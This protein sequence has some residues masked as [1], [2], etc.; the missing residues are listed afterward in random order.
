MLQRRPSAFITH[1]AFVRPGFGAHHP[2]STGRQTAVV[3]LVRA[4]GWLAKGEEKI[5]PLPPRETLLRF[6]SPEYLSALERAGT[7]AMATA[8]DRARYNLGT[9]EC[10]VFDGLWERARASVGGS[11]LAAELAASG[12]IAFHPAGGTHHG[13]PGRASGFCYLND[14]VFAILRLLD[15]GFARIVYVDLDAHHGDGVEDAFGEDERVSMISIHEAGRWPGTGATGVRAQGRIVNVATQR[16]IGDDGYR[17]L[18]DAV[19]LPFL[20]HRK[21]EALVIVLGADGLAGDPLSDMGL[22]N[23]LLWQVTDQCLAAAPAAVVLGGGGYNPWT[24]A[25]LWAGL[26][27]RLA[28]GAWPTT[29]PASARVVLSALDSDLV[30]TEDRPAR[31]T[32]TLDD[33]ATV[34]RVSA[35]DIDNLVALTKPRTCAF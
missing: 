22:S 23:E 32:T 12:T 21:P 1:P 14:P 28:G 7:A 15:L 5:A 20:A 6:H 25:R 34:G 29:L 35:G 11:I 26:W 31:W 19:L 33:V 4:L 16:G 13:R 18:A 8:E 24:T 17:R 10:P 2:L 27:G 3:D 30:D 9:M